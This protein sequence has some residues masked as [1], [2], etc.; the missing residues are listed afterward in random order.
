MSPDKAASWA[1]L[2]NNLP[3][4][5]LHPSVAMLLCAL[6]AEVTEGDVPAADAHLQPTKVV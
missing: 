5:Q 4:H 1:K 2:L 6:L 3:A